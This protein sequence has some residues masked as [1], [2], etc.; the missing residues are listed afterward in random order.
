MKRIIIPIIIIMMFSSCTAFN[1]LNA[2]KNLQY[3]FE[4]LNVGMP[5][6]GE[7]V[8]LADIAIYNP[9]NVQVEIK[10]VEY[11]IFI[12]DIKMA[13]GETEDKLIIK[14]KSKEIYHTAIVPDMKNLKENFMQLLGAGNLKGL[15]KGNITFNTS[16]GAHTFPFSIERSAKE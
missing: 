16:L 11:E 6:F 10:K 12:N 3:E 5:S 13:E 4:G 9:N 15:L 14:K 8:L 1:Q 7:V 2:I